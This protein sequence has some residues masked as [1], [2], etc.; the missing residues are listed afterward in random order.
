VVRSGGEVNE[1]WFHIHVSMFGLTSATGT[2]LSPGE[3]AECTFTGQPTMAYKMKIKNHLFSPES[4][5]R[6]H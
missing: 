6:R 5:P 3:I 2:V 1:L 4:W